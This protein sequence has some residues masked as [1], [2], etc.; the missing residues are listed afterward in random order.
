M[1]TALHN[2][3]EQDKEITSAVVTERSGTF[4]E[5]V[6]LAVPL[7]VSFLSFSLMSMFDAW[8]MGRVGTPQQGGVL[9]AGMLIWGVG[10]LFTGTLN[11]INTLV[12]QDYGAGR[13]QN[14][15]RHTCTGFV[16]A[17]IFALIVLATMPLFPHALGIFGTDASVRPHVVTYTDIVLWGMPLFFTNFVVLGFLRGLGEMRTPMVVTLIANLIN[18]GLDVVLVFGYLGFPAMGVAGA[19]LASVIARIFETLMYLSIYFRV[20]YNEKFQTRSWQ[21]PDWGDYR[22]FFKLGLPIGFT[23]IFD[24]VSWTFFS[25]YASRLRP[26]DLSAHMILFQVMHFS[27]LPA[28]AVSVSGTTLVGQYLGAKRPD[29]AKK[30][31]ITSLWFG[32]GYMTFAGVVMALAR[33]QLVSFFNPDPNVVAVGA[34]LVLIAAIFQPFDAIGIVLS[35]VLRGAGDTR[36]PMI[37]FAV[38][39]A[40]IFIPG[41]LLMGEVLEQG[42]VGAWKAA[43]VYIVVVALAHVVRYAKGN[44]TEI[45]LETGVR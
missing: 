41:V 26:S 27:F 16:V 44:W 2:E 32:L 15:R 22:R 37:V 9:L 18:V 8:I 1:E 10:S 5:V 4:K 31:A 23:W 21:K 20:E 25:V 40:V 30:S 12:A 34:T 19:A 7:M 35:G 14:I 38:C 3:S 13:Y 36:F 11:A 42:I 17:P 24:M 29:L 45:E 28:V 6:V 33:V 39:G 43:V